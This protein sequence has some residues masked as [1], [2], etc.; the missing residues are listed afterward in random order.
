MRQTH[1]RNLGKIIHTK[2]YAIEITDEA[3]A[4]MEQLYN[5]ITY[6]LLSA[7]NAMYQYNRIADAILSL[8]IL[9]E[10][11]HAMGSEPLCQ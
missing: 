7:E 8:D 11:V 10:R 4:D 2:R 5:R 3:L 9:A 1:L 6:S